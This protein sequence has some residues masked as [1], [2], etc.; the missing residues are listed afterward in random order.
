M[1]FFGPSA[2]QASVGG[3]PTV[4]DGSYTWA[5]WSQGLA[6]VAGFGL[7]GVIG[8]LLF[9]IAVSRSQRRAAAEIEAKP[10][11]FAEWR[12]GVLVV[13]AICVVLAA[14][15]VSEA[16]EDRSCH[17]PLRNGGTSIAPVASFDLKVGP[18][19]W[20]RA[21]RIIHGFGTERG[22]EI[23]SDIRSGNDFKWFQMS[24]CR[25]PGTEI[26]VQGYIEFGVV[27]ISVFQPQGGDSWRETFVE[28][29]NRIEKTWPKS[30]EFNGQTGE[31]INRPDWA[32]S[33]MQKVS[34]PPKPAD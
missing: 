3:V 32:S 11:P 9:Y 33:T 26:A 23:F 22:W 14:F 18:D 7:L 34:M 31:K 1:I 27:S 20:K 16:S 2:D 15:A 24:L 6:F 12:G 25:E 30:V 17:N 8:G 28:L 13:A 10:K 5:G 19:Q 21:E 29:L 4:I